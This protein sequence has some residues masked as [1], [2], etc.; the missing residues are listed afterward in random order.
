MR[1]SWRAT[2]RSAKPRGSH[3]SSTTPTSGTTCTSTPTPSPT[4]NGQRLLPASTRYA[5]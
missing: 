2:S 5:N 4:T 1:V 3:S